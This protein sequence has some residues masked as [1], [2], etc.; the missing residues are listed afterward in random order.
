MR[1]RDFIKISSMTVGGWTL[2][3]LL[4]VKGLAANAPE[5][6]QPSPLVRLCP[7]GK[8][9]VY[10][11]KQESGQGVQ[12]SLPMIMAEELEADLK[13]I[14]VEAMPYDAAKSGDYSTGGST[15]TIRQYQPLRKAGATAREMLIAA[16]AKEWNVSIETCKAERS[17]V[18]NSV[19]GQE[20]AYKDLIEK[21][22][23]MPVPKDP[24]LKN[25]KDFRVIGKQGQKKTNLKE[26]VSGKMKYGID[27]K[28]PG[29][30]YA[31]IV[32]CPVL[33]GK[34]KSWDP[35]S[36]SK[37]DGIVQLF[38]MKEM[39]DQIE[40]R[41]GVAIVANNR[42]SA[43]KAQQRLK[44]EWDLSKADA[45][46][47]TASYYKLQ[48]SKLKEKADLIYNEKG[49][50]VTDSFDANAA[51]V[52]KAVYRIPFVAHATMEPPN[53]T[54]QF[55]EGKFE[56][57]GGFQNPGKV[58]SAG[59]KYFNL[60]AADVFINLQP[61]GGGFGR[62]LSADY[63][64][65]AMQIAKVMEGKPVQLIFTRADDIRFD[66]YRPCSTHQ[67]SAK[68]SASKKPDQWQHHIVISPV[69][70][71]FQGNK[72][73]PGWFSAEAGGGAY[74]DM[75][76]DIPQLRAPMTRTMPP[77]SLGWW[78]SV[79]FTYNNVVIECFVDELAKKAGMDGLSYRL[80]LLA[81]L[82]KGPI[83][84]GSVYDP[85]R[86]ENVLK[87]CAEKIGW[88]KKRAA[89]RGVGIACCFYNH[90]KAYTAH[91]FEVSVNKEK[92]VKIHK[93]IV[94][95]D[96]GMV[97]DPDGLTNQ[98][99]GSYVWAMSA[100]MKSEI[101]VLNG[102]VQ[103]SSFFDF[104]VVRMNDL[105]PIDITIV[106]STEEPGGAGETSVPSAMPAMM[107]AIAAATNVRVREMPLKRLG[108]SFASL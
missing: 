30:L 67:L 1:R 71:F 68:I 100:L 80:N 12:T 70:D 53:C 60:K 58:A 79:N 76:Y 33:N 42:W 78:R 21:A 36:I 34:V 61:M 4:P 85:R 96:I 5:C 101:T 65:E 35:A 73:N 69:M 31:V 89:G 15:S 62:K 106:Q 25:Y 17:K 11:V 64:A 77:V 107:N 74:G 40:N 49:D 81:G 28:L 9:I 22:S 54:A 99:Q 108:Y 45:T 88:N 13:D 48:E 83:K 44:V 32:R 39:G 46:V 37:V 10:V 82:Q 93:A 6:W 47:S 97:I 90:A 29:M 18:V 72:G 23:K 20:F 63:G 87:Q 102:A 24:A 94:V 50:V 19:T 52:V 92:Q 51:G 27:L 105:P 43:L 38:E 75:Y 16:A 26:I 56:I 104:E 2:A 103:Q 59:A 95:T 8:I 86:M 3:Q 84:G 57:W 98:V 91:A 41:S 55:K 7:D 66:V 14:V